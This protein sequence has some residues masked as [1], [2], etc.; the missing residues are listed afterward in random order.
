MREIRNSIRQIL[1]TPVRTVLFLLL[2]AVSVCLLVLGVHLQMVNREQMRLF[3]SSFTTIGTVRQVENSLETDAMWYAEQERYLI[4]SRAVFDVRLSPEVLYFDDA[5]YIHPPRQRPYY[6]A[7]HQGYVISDDE[8]LRKNEMKRSL[9][10]AELEP[11]E[12]CVPSKPVRM[13]VNRVLRGTIYG[14]L[15]EVW[16]WDLFRENPPALQGGKTYVMQLEESV[17]KDE[18][19]GGWKTIY[20]S[21]GSWVESTQYDK[22]GQRISDNLPSSDGWEEVTEG[23]Y[24][25]P[26]G[27]RWLALI[28][29][30]EQYLNTI[31]VTP[32][33]STNLL[34]S[35][36]NGSASIGDGRDISEEEYQ[37]GE[38]VCLIPRYFAKNNNLNVGDTL[39]L[40]LYY[41]NYARSPSGVYIP[42]GW[43]IPNGSPLNAQG[44]VYPVF[45]YGNYTIVGIY[46][47]H[48]SSYESSDFDMGGNEVIIPA[49][50]VKN[51]DENNILAYRPMQAYNTSFQIPNGSIASYTEAWNKLG[52]TNVDIQFYDK[53]YTQLKSGLD[54]MKNVSLILLLSGTA[55]TLLILT[56]F[57]YLFITTQKKRTAIERSLG[58]SK[59]SCLLSLLSG[60]VLIALIG[61]FMGGIAGF[62]VSGSVQTLVMLTGQVYDTTFSSWVNSADVQLTLNTTMSAPDMFIFVLVALGTMLAAVVLAL[63]GIWGNLRSEPLTLLSTRR[64]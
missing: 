21:S 57:T 39:E 25:T 12:D 44:E 37:L 26:R 9:M 54:A 23:F 59:T 45:D 27:R 51:S 5:N 3:E 4:S 19:T 56:F 36:Y 7:Y 47:V 46:D 42:E 49:A 16:F 13:K 11:L 22:N 53:G 63:V 60:V 6:G 24:E 2:L 35:F 58:M 52:I 61:C 17:M 55:A 30:F 41:A 43:G 1:R 20:T 64:E 62:M 33:N 32:T 29:G 31:P 8:V 28:E 48:N 34:M 50:A 14:D 18:K 38:R 10:I 40:P 15:S